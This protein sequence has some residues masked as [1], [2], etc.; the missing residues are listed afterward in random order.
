V[1]ILIWTQER[2]NRPT[3]S[4]F[5][6]PPTQALYS[7]RQACHSAVRKIL[8]NRVDSMGPIEGPA[9]PSPDLPMNTASVLLKKNTQVNVDNIKSHRWI[10]YRWPGQCEIN[11]PQSSK[12]HFGKCQLL[13]TRGEEGRPRCLC[14]KLVQLRPRHT[15]HR[16]CISYSDAHQFSILF[17][18]TILK[19]MSP[20]VA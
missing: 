6:P 5:S 13:F 20:K 7:E 4:S 3:T 17:R 16:V 9:L 1:K 12:L 14:S 18:M 10:K 8:R 19:R 2:H 11:H 15:I